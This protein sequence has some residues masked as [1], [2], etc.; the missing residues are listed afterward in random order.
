M[1]ERADG[2]QSSSGSQA[3]CSGFPTT[4]QAAQQSRAVFGI[5][6]E[7]LGVKRQ[8]HPKLSQL[9]ENKPSKLVLDDNN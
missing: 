1:G 2:A 8:Q 5:P 3:G 7:P 4:K 9:N 6:C